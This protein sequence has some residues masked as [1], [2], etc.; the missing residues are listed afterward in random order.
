M[1]SS[2][3]NT[4]EQFAHIFERS[5]TEVASAPGRVNLIGEH[6]DYTGGFVLPLALAQRTYVVA[7]PRND[8]TVRVFSQHTGEFH[9]FSIATQP[10]EV[11]G[12][13]AYVAGMIWSLTSDG[14]ACPG[15]DLLIDSDVP[16]GAGLSSS[17]ALEYAV[18]VAMCALADVNRTATQLALLA[19]RAENSYVGMPSGNMDQLASM[20]GVVNRALFID[21]RSLE[22]EAVPIQ[23]DQASLSLL[24]IDSQAP[25]RLVD[26]GYAARRHA[27]QHATDELGIAALR[28]ICIADLE[29]ALPQLSSDLLR[30][31]VRHVV[32]ENV[33]VLDVVALLRDGTDLPAIGAYLTQSHNSLRDDFEVTVPEVNTAVN[34]AIRA[35]AY[36]ARMI[37]GGFGGC[38]IALVQTA[39]AES[40]ADAVI[41]QFAK[42]SFTA[43]TWFLA[44]P[45]DGA[46]LARF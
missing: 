34:A 1:N 43:P 45:S 40:I 15:A 3:A 6:T 42:A 7:A 2:V 24:V 27:C 37:G 19:Q 14:I 36:G 46:S 16:L 29:S 26:G 32:T 30:R 9:E 18:A 38:V 17:A 28:D 8:T 11:R 22:V 41:A 25:H 44:T 39:A 33:R 35:G 10:G 12:W 23:L 21:T 4:C 5:A 31:R 13:A 20:H